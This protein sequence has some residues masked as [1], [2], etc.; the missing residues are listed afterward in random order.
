[1]ST[2]LAGGDE[3]QIKL[4]WRLAGRFCGVSESTRRAAIRDSGFFGHGGELSAVSSSAVSESVS[5]SAVWLEL[6]GFDG[7]VGCAGALSTL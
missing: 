6:G 7:T 2:N 5:V 1:M 3:V 4:R